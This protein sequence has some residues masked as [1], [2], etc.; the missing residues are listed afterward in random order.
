MLG[1]FNQFYL[2]KWVGTP[3]MVKEDVVIK[4]EEREYQ[5]KKS[6]W[7]CGGVWLNGVPRAKRKH[8][9]GLV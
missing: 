9:V 8:T 2:V 5:L 4:V 7:V 6:E 1:E 3:W